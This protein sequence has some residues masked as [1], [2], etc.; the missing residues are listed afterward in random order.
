M[1]NYQK[2]ALK[3]PESLLWSPF[4]WMMNLKV[5][6]VVVIYVFLD[7]FLF[8]FMF[9]DEE[10]ILGYASA[11]ILLIGMFGTFS[12]LKSIVV[13]DIENS[14]L[15]YA[16]EKSTR[17]L[18]QVNSGNEQVKVE[19]IEM[20]ILPNNPSK[21]LN[22]LSLFSN[23]VKEARD[24]KFESTVLIMKR[25]KEEASDHIFR[26]QSIQKI[27]L[28]LGILGAFVGLILVLTRLDF[29]DTSN[30]Q[31]FVFKPLFNALNVSFGTSVAGLLVAIVLGFLMQLIKSS[32]EVYFKNMKAATLYV[33]SLARNSIVDD[34]YFNEFQKVKT[35]GYSLNKRFYS[36]SRIMESQIEV[37]NN[38]IE[39]L[40]ATKNT[41]DKFVWDI[42]ESQ[43]K[44]IE[45]LN[46]TF[47]LLIPE[48]ISV[49]FEENF[50]KVT[51]KI[52]NSFSER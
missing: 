40:I 6:F 30:V 24:R 29:S 2:T 17:L 15:L 8:D 39:N 13:F 50:D 43:N 31:V 48:N 21:A 25:Y 33:L 3:S 32:Q 27:A 38:G 52:T 42:S 12:A 46:K 36:Q 9:P 49:R 26:L 44:F 37:I 14:I 51:E 1:K 28:H 10:G 4:Y 22:I 7:C 45:R 35:S 23:I 11:P 16:E 18:E 34:K 5:V 20:R 41:F 47:D 19:D